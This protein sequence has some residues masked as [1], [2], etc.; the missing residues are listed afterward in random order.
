MGA[1]CAKGTAAA[2]VYLAHHCLQL[3][4]GELLL[5]KEAK[6][7]LKSNVNGMTLPMTPTSGKAS[8]RKASISLICKTPSPF[9]SYLDR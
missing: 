9:V 6:G 1:I 5:T 8:F 7:A 4:G 3:L 2:V